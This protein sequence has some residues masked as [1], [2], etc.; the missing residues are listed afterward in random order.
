MQPP[1]PHCDPPGLT[2]LRLVLI[3]AL[4]CADEPLL[5]HLAAVMQQGDLL[6]CSPA[7]EA[8]ASALGQARKA[9][10]HARQQ[11]GRNSQ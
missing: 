9:T 7:P 5:L 8:P 10:R 3:G 11:P 2:S 1:C 4:F 6:Q